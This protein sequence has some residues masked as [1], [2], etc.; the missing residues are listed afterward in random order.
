M[1]PHVKEEIDIRLHSTNINKEGGLKLGQ[2]S[3]ERD[4][5]VSRAAVFHRGYEYPRGY[6]KTFYGVRKIIYIYIYII[7]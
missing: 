1:N 3:I 6:A 5:Q 2:T 7:Y 4:H